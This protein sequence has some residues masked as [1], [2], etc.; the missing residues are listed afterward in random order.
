MIYNRIVWFIMKEFKME[1]MN[2]GI[3]NKDG[4]MQLTYERCV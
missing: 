1:L 2:L 4:I 3:E